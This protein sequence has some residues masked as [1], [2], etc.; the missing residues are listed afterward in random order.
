M[1][2]DMLVSMIRQQRELQ[3][4]LGNRFTVSPGDRARRVEHIKDM[5]LAAIVEITEALNEVS[6]KPWTTGEPVL[7]KHAVG[8]E[9][10]DA[11]QFI[12]NM[13]FAAYVE[14]SDEDVTRLEEVYQPRPATGA[15]S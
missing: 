4:R 10:S 1:M 6:W 12:M 8:G 5:G 2:E 3:H 14:L 15:Y 11:F 13:W 9:L 7:K